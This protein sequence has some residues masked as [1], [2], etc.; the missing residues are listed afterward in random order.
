M[1]GIGLVFAGFLILGVFGGEYQDM[2]IQVSEFGDCYEY[3]EDSPPVKTDCVEETQDS[4]IFFAIVIGLIAAGIISL[5]KGY[6]GKWDNEVKPE[7]MLGP[8]G[9]RKED[10]DDKEKD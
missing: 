6:R 3:F 1:I 4:S 10:S 7:E 9:E 5:V 8:G 2:N